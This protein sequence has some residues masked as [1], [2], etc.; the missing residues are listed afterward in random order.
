MLPRVIAGVVLCLI[1]ALWIGQGVG[2]V[3]G[4]FMTGHGF[5]AVLGAAL[6]LLG[7]WLVLAGVRRGRAPRT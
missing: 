4:S 1:G 7:G 6:V 3:E 5:Y 2:A